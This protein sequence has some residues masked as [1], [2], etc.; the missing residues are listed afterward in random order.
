[1]YIRLCAVI[2]ALLYECLFV[3]PYKPSVPCGKLSLRGCMQL[4]NTIQKKIIS[5]QFRGLRWGVKRLNVY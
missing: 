3:C 1:M 5:L 2:A 4:A